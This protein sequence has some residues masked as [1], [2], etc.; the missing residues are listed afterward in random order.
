VEFLLVP[1]ILLL[2]GA[3]VRA[4][5]S[6]RGERDPGASI[7]SFTRALSAMEPRGADA[8]GTQ[9]HDDEAVIDL[10]DSPAQRTA[11]PSGRPGR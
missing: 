3:I 10:T 11:E 4:A 9:A 8:R 5:W 2:V 1:V 7:D 6:S